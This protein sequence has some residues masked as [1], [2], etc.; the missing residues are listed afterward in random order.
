[1]VLMASSSVFP[2]GMVGRL[3][4]GEDGEERRRGGVDG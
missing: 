3:S 1:M 4:M 2:Y